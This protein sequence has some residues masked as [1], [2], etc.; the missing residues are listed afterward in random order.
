[1]VSGCVPYFIS[2][3]VVLWKHFELDPFYQ[4]VISGFR[5]FVCRGIRVVLLV[6]GVVSF[7][8]C[9]VWFLLKVVAQSTYLLCSIYLDNF[10]V[11]I[12][13]VVSGCVPYF[14]SNVVV[15]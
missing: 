10:C 15:L 3:V 14:V 2:N 5:N 1:V 12:S 9:L 8:D 4:G 7:P 13:L 11:V 6:L